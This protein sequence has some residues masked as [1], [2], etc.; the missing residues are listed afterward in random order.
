MESDGF[1]NDPVTYQ[2][3]INDKDVEHWK[4]AMESEM[5]SIYTNQ[6]WT[7]VDKPE[8]IKPIYRLQ[9]DLQNKIRTNW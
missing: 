4:K 3:A 2:E 8:G 9:M 1:D 7:L 5:D 6:V